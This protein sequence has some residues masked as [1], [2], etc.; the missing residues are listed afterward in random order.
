MN[1]YSE[2]GKNGCLVLWIPGPCCPTDDVGGAVVTSSATLGAGAEGGTIA[3]ATS[4]PE[5]TTWGG[6]TGPSSCSPS[7]RPLRGPRWRT[8]RDDDGFHGKGSGFPHHDLCLFRQGRD[9]GR[10]G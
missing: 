6:V 9:R 1:T 10:L 8:R 7:G 5:M 2:T 4:G 3:G